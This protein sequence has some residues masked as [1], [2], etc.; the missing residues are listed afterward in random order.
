MNP[1]HLV[2]ASLIAAFLA[3]SQ[4]A[5][6][7]IRG[8]PSCGKWVSE[9]APDKWQFV[10]NLSWVVGFLSGMAQESQK[11]VLS[12]T[13]NNSISLWMDNYCRANPLKDV[14]DGSLVLFEELAKKKG[15]K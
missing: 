11:N 12:G 3:S 15:I 14:H 6:V 8:A 1:R 13:D 7:T 2:Q 10:V 9:S 4:A 5:A